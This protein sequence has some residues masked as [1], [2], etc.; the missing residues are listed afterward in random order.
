VCA[1]VGPANV[2]WS[3]IDDL[4]QVTDP[5]MCFR[6][7]LGEH[8]ACHHHSDEGHPHALMMCSG[9]LEDA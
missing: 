9:H 5:G 8:V 4:G 6:V 3:L 7:S 2:S 1:V